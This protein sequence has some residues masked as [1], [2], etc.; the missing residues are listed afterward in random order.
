MPS[1]LKEAG[2]LQPRLDLIGGMQKLE[3]ES[4]GVCVYVC[5]CVRARG[6]THGPRGREEISSAASGPGEVGEG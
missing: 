6:H 2:G 4:R 1:H 5:V 3:E